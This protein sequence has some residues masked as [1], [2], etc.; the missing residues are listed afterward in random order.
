MLIVVALTAAWSMNAAAADV[1]FLRD[2]APVLV[3]RCAGCHGSQ[4]PRGDYRLLTFD[5]MLKPGSSDEQPVVAG[6]PTESEIYRRVV[7]TDPGRRM[8]P[9]DD[10]LTAEEIAALRGWIEGG[11]AFDGVDR[12]A[13][14][15]SQLPPRRHPEAP[16]RYKVAVPVFA[17]AFSPD[18]KELAVGGH[19]EVTIWDPLTGKLLRRLGRLPQRIHA[20]AYD[21][22]GKKLL[23]GGGSAGEY[24]EALLIDAH[25]PAVRRTLGTF[26]DVVLSACFD[27]AGKRVAAGSADFTVSCFPVAAGKPLWQAQ[28][29][30]DWVNGVA[31]SPDGR[32][33]VTAGK[34]RTC[35]VLDAATGS[36]FT[37][38][39]GH[40]QQYGPHSGRF[41]V[42]DVA[43][44]A[45][46]KAYT[47]GEGDVVRVW[48][49]V[50]AKSESGDAGDMEE[51]FAKTGHTRFL[52][53]GDKKPVNRLVVR[54]DRVFVAG[55]DGLM[56]EFDVASSRLTR[57]YTGHADWVFAVDYDA[58]NRRLASA[59]FDGEVRI[60]DA[61][62]GACVQHFKAAPGL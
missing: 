16:A 56:R 18:G 11:A 20:L 37:T 58:R 17:L 10:P 5:G 48:E 13:T 6:K 43:F 32:F 22:E 3:S 27:P 15:K 62:T 25:D 30:S 59:G 21:A 23:V 31:F 35:K 60:W 29:H 52:E 2:V 24:G 8:P 49:P 53:L 39:N 9:G 54:G 41:V 40:M 28:L 36:L 34:D 38:Y 33:V 45:A 61:A 50:K 14:L 55:A 51:R 19:H 57:S 44:D 1:A 46:G 7:E 26:D 4:K 47:G 42:N 12:T